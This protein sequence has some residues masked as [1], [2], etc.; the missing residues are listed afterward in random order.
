MT[1]FETNPLILLKTYMQDFKRS[2]TNNKEV[3]R[4]YNLRENRVTS[5]THDVQ[6]YTRFKL[7]NQALYGN[8]YDEIYS[9]RATRGGVSITYQ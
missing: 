3:T 7:T 8:V 5:V 9:D 2:H 1:E 4:P 6:T